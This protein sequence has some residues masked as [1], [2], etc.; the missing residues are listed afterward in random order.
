MNMEAGLPTA[1][2]TAEDEVVQVAK[3]PRLTQ[4]KRIAW[5]RRR[6]IAGITAIALVLGL[7]GTLLMTPLYTATSQI[8]IS[9]EGNRVTEIQ[10][11][12]REAT[13]AE[14]EFYQTQY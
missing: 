1:T 6:L 5:H 14:L 4:I 8:E 9:R 13:T 10:G 2:L 11:V 7:V 3:T 12:E